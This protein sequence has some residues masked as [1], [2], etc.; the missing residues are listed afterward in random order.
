MINMSVYNQKNMEQTKKETDAY[1]L[2]NKIVDAYYPPEEFMLIIVYGKLGY[3]KSAFQFK[4]TRDV[5]MKEYGM[6]QK[7]AWEYIKQLIVFHPEQFFEKLDQSK[8]LGL[9]M[10]KLLI[11]NWDDA[12]LWLWCMEWDNPFLEALG[13]WL[14]VARTDITCLILSSPVVKFIF[15]KLRS[16]GDAMTVRIIKDTD[17]THPWRRLAKPYEQ[18]VLPDQ[19]KTRVKSYKPLEFNCKLPTDFFKWYKPKRDKYAKMAKDQMK[20]SWRELQELSEGLDIE[21]YPDLKMP[22]LSK[23]PNKWTW[24]P[25]TINQRIKQREVIP[26]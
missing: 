12:G 14:N 15:K 8:E 2:V 23:I 21:N 11:L 6:P 17:A 13:K 18:Y 22:K 26:D 19:K 10:D 24:N 1:W 20:G 4:I 3:G 25:T 9:Y 16:F 7:E 5:L